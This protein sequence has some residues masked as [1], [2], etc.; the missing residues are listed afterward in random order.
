[1]CSMLSA[2]PTEKVNIIK[3]DS[4]IIESIDALVDRKIVHIEDVS[5]D[6]E[7]G[8]IIE[9]TLP[10][11]SKEQYLV[12]DRGFFRGI[13]GGI[14]SH[15][16]VKVE[17][18][19]AYTKVSRGS[20]INQYHINNAEKVNIQ[21]TDN[22]TTYNITANDISLMDTL[23]KLADGLEDKEEIILNIDSMQDNIGKKSFAEKYN[24]FVQSVAN[25]MTIF[26]PF[27]PALTNL[28][29]K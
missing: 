11:G 17:K 10:T 26:A 19:T 27:I 2:F 25:H 1:M 5:I 3:R 7:E 16:E 20:V 28:L 22:S 6:I 15:Y 13:P 18:Q 24:A 8:D 9:R 12:I 21:S 29:M 14:P 23:R 4:S